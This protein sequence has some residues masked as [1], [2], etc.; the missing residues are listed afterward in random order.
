M[1]DD[2]IQLTKLPRK[3]TALPTLRRL[4]VVWMLA[5]AVC[6]PCIVSLAD[7]AFGPTA[8]WKPVPQS[9]VKAQLDQYLQ[10]KKQISEQLK[11]IEAVWTEA[12]EALEVDTLE[13]IAKS[14]A[15]VDPQ[16][17]GLLAHC[18]RPFKVGP[19]PEFPWLL[20]K[21][22]PPLVRNNM[23]LYYGRWL[24]QQ[25]MDDDAALLL[26]GM[27][28]EQVVAPT[29]LLFYQAV[30]HHRLVNT[31]ESKQAAIKLL[32]RES[33]LPKRYQEI[34][35]L[36]KNDLKEIEYDSLDHISRRMRDIRR[37]LEL[38]QA[39]EKVRTVEDGVIESLDK[40][41]KEMED[42]QQQ[43]QQASSGGGPSSPDSK[44]AQNS[45]VAPLK[46]A[47]RVD[48]KDIGDSSDW[49][50]LP[51]KEREAALQQI[52]KEFPAHFRDAIEQYFRK[53]AGEGDSGD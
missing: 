9:A 46:G 37:R 34:A 43:Q 45:Q 29:Q 41:I 23:R 27:E 36:M 10:S 25:Q 30:V 47:G 50:S 16:V 17:Q 15:M 39:G 5:L 19:Q 22:T 49:G 7:D 53:I 33:E 35:N 8:T 48:R 14:L 11:Q 4:V 42:Q 13:L 26:V 18:K 32:E 44:P 2:S 6:C 20:E 24:A 21:E 40:L 12:P 51:P 38:G 3:R 31:K 28:P 1:S 52:G